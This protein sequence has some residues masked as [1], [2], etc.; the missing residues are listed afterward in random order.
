VVSQEVRDSGLCRG[1]PL[2][3][4]SLEKTA[5]TECLLLYWLGHHCFSIAAFLMDL[6]TQWLMPKNMHQCNRGDILWQN[7][8]RKIFHLHF[9]SMHTSF[10]MEKWSNTVLSRINVT[11][12]KPVRSVL[13]RSPRSK[14]DPWRN[15]VLADNFSW[16]ALVDLLNK[17]MHIVH[18]GSTISG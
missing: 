5:C 10:L 9:P 11:V 7:I 13:R 2:N 1:N 6:H 16:L 4:T 18:T 8:A 3:Q 12:M 15:N 17:C 14:I